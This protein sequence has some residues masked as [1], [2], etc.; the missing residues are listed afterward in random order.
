MD[1]SVS[2]HPAAA[3]DELRQQDVLERRE[4]RQEVMELVDETDLEAAHTCAIGIAHPHAI[5]AVDENLTA[6][7]ALKQTSNV[8]QC[9]FA[10]A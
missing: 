1:R 8:Q 5:S 7:G 10:G 2:L 9:R 3:D 6:V 4:L